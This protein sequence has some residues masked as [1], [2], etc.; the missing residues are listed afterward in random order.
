MAERA[1]RRGVQIVALKAGRSAVG[2]KATASHTG[3]IASSHAVYTDV[4]EQAGIITV[5]SL[6]ETLAAIEV[7]GFMPPPAHFGRPQGRRRGA[8]F[9]GRRRRAAG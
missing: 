5:D 8:E 7:L 3:K 9:F 4:M 1:R 6:A 2:Q